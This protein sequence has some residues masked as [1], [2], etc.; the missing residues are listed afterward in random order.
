ML[1]LRARAFAEAG[2][3]RVLGVA[4]VLA[5]VGA[6]V[7]AALAQVPAVRLAVAAGLGLVALLAAWAATSTLSPVGRRTLDILELLLTAAAIPAAL[8]AMG[9]F[10][11]VRGA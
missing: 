4:A 5:G 7:P 2:P 9:L 3:A 10:A 8:A 11:L 1:L 6:A